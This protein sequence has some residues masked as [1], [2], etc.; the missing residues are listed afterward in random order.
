MVISFRFR[1]KNLLPLLVHFI[2][3]GEK[4]PF[5][6]WRNFQK[7]EH[8]E[9]LKERFRAIIY[10]YCIIKP[11][12]NNAA[13]ILAVQFW[14]G[15]LLLYGIQNWWESWSPLHFSLC[16]SVI[17]DNNQLL[18]TTLTHILRI[19]FILIYQWTHRKHLLMDTPKTGP[20]G[21]LHSPENRGKRSKNQL[22]LP[23][24]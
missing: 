20:W 6:T 1:M 19:F 23:N 4:F 18:N 14:L 9:E 12:N 17:F 16:C 24:F 10:F 13:L 7:Q 5:N 22:N 8:S 15:L 2:L 21:G 3:M 11:T